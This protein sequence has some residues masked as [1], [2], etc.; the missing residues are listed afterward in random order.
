MNR[1]IPP[2]ASLCRRIFSATSSQSGPDLCYPFGGIAI[3]RDQ[4]ILVPDICHPAILRVDPV[5][6][7][8]SCVS[9]KDIWGA[10]LGSGPMFTGDLYDIAVLSDGSLLVTDCFPEPHSP[11]PGDT[12]LAVIK[13]NPNTGDR[14]ILSGPGVGSGPNFGPGGPRALAVDVGLTALREESWMQYR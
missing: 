10:T 14:T 11:F 7:N 12:L 8:R 5:T 2:S 3:D 4:T 13:V 6:G 1:A 9:G